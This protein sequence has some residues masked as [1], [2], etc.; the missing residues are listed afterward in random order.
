MAWEQR[1]GVSHGEIVPF[2]WMLTLSEMQN[3]STGLYFHHSGE[4]HVCL[5]II[6]SLP[7]QCI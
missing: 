2:T 4:Y 1:V 3:V 5:T 6:N 7:E